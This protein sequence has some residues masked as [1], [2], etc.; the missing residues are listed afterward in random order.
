M[1]RIVGATVPALLLC[2]AAGPAAAHIAF[3]EPTART[4]SQKDGPCGT[5]TSTR[6]TMVCRYRPGATVMIRFEETI[7]HSGH[8]RLSFDDDGQD[9]RNPSG[10]NDTAVGDGV[11]I[12]DNA[13]ADRNVNGADPMYTYE[14]TL[15]DVT[16]D[17]C[18]LQLI[19]VMTTASTYGEAD[20]YYQ[21]AD[22]E[23]T[24]DAPE[25]PT[26]DCIAV[27]GGDD[28]DGGGGGGG[29]GGGCNVATSGAGGLALA[30]LALVVAWR[31][32]R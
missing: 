16:C 31:R 27:D 5:P 25:T 1:R 19:Q 29:G 14:V 8:F 3:H 12:L 24:S 26:P 10:P 11:I 28:P 6:G 2:L 4:T 13:I 20:L 9:F 18:T 21:C 22:I 30:A 23:L 32:R 7:E 15:P 17:N